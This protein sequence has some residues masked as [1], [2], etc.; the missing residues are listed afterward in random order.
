MLEI[1]TVQVGE[2]PELGRTAGTAKRSTELFR[3]ADTTNRRGSKYSLGCVTHLLRSN[4]CQL[5]NLT[6]LPNLDT[7]QLYS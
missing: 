4:H 6:H 5:N 1:R 7:T 3:S 2:V